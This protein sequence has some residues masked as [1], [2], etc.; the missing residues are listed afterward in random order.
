MLT[1]CTD[2]S[3]SHD[4]G[5]SSNQE[6]LKAYPGK[7]GIT[8]A[9][10][11]TFLPAIIYTTP[12][13]QN[14]LDGKIYAI[15]GVVTSTNTM[16]GATYFVIDT[17]GGDVA[18]IDMLTY[19]T[20]ALDGVDTDDLRPYFPLPAIGEQVVI[21][22]EY[23]GHSNSLDLAMFLYGGSDYFARALISAAFDSVFNETTS[24]NTQETIPE[25]SSPETIEEPKPT[26]PPA[27]TPPATVAPTEKPTEA[28][29]PTSSGPTTGEENALKS[30]KSYLSI[31]AFSYEGLIKQLNFEGYTNTEATYAADNC[32]ADW[33]GQAV[34]SAKN[35]LNVSAFSYSG[36]IR[37]LEYEGFTSTQATYGADNCGADW[38]E[39]AAKSA[40]NYVSIMSFSRDGLISQL[41]YEGF[42]HEQAVHGA[43]SVG[44]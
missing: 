17:V 37:Q 41:E 12:A 30:A 10:T 44:L 23:M 20:S 31:M 42:T 39:Q 26:T 25:A 1:A 16:G 24:S 13:S 36:L 43:N 19:D 4:T 2:T 35:Y 8:V 28:P 27:T 5:L 33:N 38:Y 40:A 11:E 7:T 32:N 34:K 29:A 6:T 15:E 3:G 22:A 9:D 21:I 14:G 18:V